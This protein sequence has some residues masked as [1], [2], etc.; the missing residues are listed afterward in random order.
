MTDTVQLTVDSGQPDLSLGPLSVEVIGTDATAAARTPQTFTLTS[1]RLTHSLD[2][3]PGRYAV[4]A[5]RP[6]GER[7][8]RMVTLQEGGPATVH[9][10]D[11][12]GKSPNEFLQPET[13][14]GDVGLQIPEPATETDLEASTLRPHGVLK[15]A[16]ARTLARMVANRAKSTTAAPLDQELRLQFWSDAPLEV[17]SC[18]W[19]PTFL[20]VGIPQQIHTQLASAAALCDVSGFG[21]VVT[22]PAFHAPLE[23]SFNIDAVTLRAAARYENPSGLRL[24]VA[25][26]HVRDPVM[27]DL[28]AALA[29]PTV[30]NADAIWS[31]NYGA[32]SI[33]SALEQLAMKFTRP[34]EAIVAAHFLLRFMP[35]KLPLAWADNLCH[36]A[37]EAADGPVIAAWARL[38]GTSD[39]DSSRV[40]SDFRELLLDAA[41]RRY[42]LCART[43]LLLCQGLRF[44]A[45]DAPERRVLEEF[46]E[47][48]AHAG[49]LD[50]H[51]GFGPEQPGR[52]P[53]AAQLSSKS[54][55][56]VARVF[57]KDNAIVRCELPSSTAAG[58]AP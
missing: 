33:E 4:V 41:K 43:R 27:A 29:A 44:S 35:D 6:S 13:L 39:R 30:H 26:P 3:S 23:L 37:A 19:G 53:I 28:L 12:I 10:A 57:L 52:K 32:G 24:P 31:C 1:G 2:L 48:G 14:R 47:F 11:G 50:A 25:V 36:A 55:R 20:K 56:L 54:P 49:G 16:G 42:T 34:A 38:H 40:D 18:H 15:G 46:L 5:R 22:A 45:P 21:P 7:L 8:T 58:V 17:T 51:W 9:L